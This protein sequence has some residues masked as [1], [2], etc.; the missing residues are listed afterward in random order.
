MRAMSFI[1]LG[2]ATAGF[3]GSANAI[4]VSQLQ[5][6]IAAGQKVTVIDIRD[7]KLFAQGHIPPAINIPASL[8]PQKHLP[9]LGNVVIYDDGLG[10]RG[11]AAL[12]RAAAVL[13]EKPGIKVEILSGGYAA[14]QASG[15]V[16]TEGRGLHHEAFDYITYGE[17]AAVDP[18]DVMLVD[19]RKLT[20]LIAKNTGALTDLA[21]EFP[22]C[23]VA[24]AVAREKDAAATPLV[25]LIDSADGSAEAQARLLKAGG[26]R[27]FAILAGGELAIERKGRPGLA[28]T[29]NQLNMTQH[30]RLSSTPVPA[31]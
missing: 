26:V 11:T 21:Q 23:R 2:W 8:C 25:V 29:G 16:T 18:K 3:L 30:H 9:P 14:W 6:E 27:R 24:S 13:A 22:G 28:R 19:L 7:T 12:D 17:L 31:Q 20:P 5:Q 4:S 15:A 1:L 10:R